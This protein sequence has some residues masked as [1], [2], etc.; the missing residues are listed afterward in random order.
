MKLFSFLV[1]P[2]LGLSLNLAASSVDL[3]SLNDEQMRQFAGD[4]FDSM[5]Q[6]GAFGDL[7]DESAELAKSIA[8]TIVGDPQL[9]QDYQ[10][11]TLK[12]DDQ[13]VADYA[14][15]KN[16]K[17]AAGKVTDKVKDVG[18]KVVDKV[19]DI[20]K[21][22]VSKVKKISAKVFNTAKDAASAIAS[23][24]NTVLSTVTSN[25]TF[26]RVMSISIGVFNKVSP[27]AAAAIGAVL[28]VT[29]PAG[30]VAMAA[31]L[32]TAI[33]VLNKV[34]TPDTFNAAMKI[35]AA[36]AALADAT[37]NKNGSKS[38]A[39]ADLA[40]G[41]KEGIAIIPDYVAPAAA[42]KASSDKPATNQ[43]KGEAVKMVGEG[44]TALA[45]YVAGLSDIQK[46]DPKMKPI[47]DA[48][49]AG[50]AVAASLNL[51]ALK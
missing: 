2:L 37:L 44:T 33:G 39:V 25:E 34:I 5:N 40:E 14:I 24:A 20:G 38:A 13:F 17:K 47:F 16:I 51:Q 6:K 41:V 42:A 4:V 12:L 49:N 36:T 27:Y 43:Q 22:G 46:R 1:L 30:G 29:V 50:K 28:V 10:D 23:V 45:E 8:Q 7:D 9:L 15:G 32:N 21:A 11:G 3:N 18:G 19:T 48:L 35:A 26:M 31:A